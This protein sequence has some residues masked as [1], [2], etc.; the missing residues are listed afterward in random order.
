MRAMVASCCSTAALLTAV[1]MAAAEG[2]GG[3]LPLPSEVTVTVDTDATH[4]TIEGWGATLPQVAFDDWLSDPTPQNYDR[5]DPRD[6]VSDSLREELLDAAVYDLGLNRFR[7][8]VGPQVEMENDDNDPHTIRWD[9]FRLKWQD[10]Q[11]SRWVLPIKA[12]LE[13]RGDPLVL[14]VS[15]DLGSDLTP[16]WLLQPD[17][18]AEFAVATL[19]HLQQTHALEPNYWSV[20]NEP[21]NQRPGDPALVAEL[22]A[23]TGSR[24]RDAG[25][26]TLMSG[27]EVVTPG[28]IPAYMQALSRTPDAFSQLG[29]LTYHL[30][31]DP[32]NTEQRHEIR[33]WGR[34]LSVT[35]AQTEWLEGR[36]MEVAR[37][38]YL[39]LT[40]ADA[41]VWEQYGLAWTRN[42]YNEGGA[43]TTS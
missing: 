40:E 16:A 24:I 17:E 9:A 4:Q 15:Y 34:R 11:V 19:T 27:P 42:P 14:Y 32:L 2:W 37:A 33:D 13:R 22:I 6:I 43:A 35:T 26:R 25:F 3:D 10:A 12:R 41:S 39:D 8:E 5:L 1:P 28:Q 21:G 18:Y 38:L 31:W 29:Q 36:G 7:I 23:A 30:Y 20:L